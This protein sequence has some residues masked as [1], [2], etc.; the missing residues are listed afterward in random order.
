MLCWMQHSDPQDLLGSLSAVLGPSTA[1]PP[2]CACGRLRRWQH[3]KR[4]S[5]RP[6]LPELPSTSAP[7]Q[8]A[9][10]RTFSSISFI[11]LP[12]PT[13]S[14]VLSEPG[15]GSMAPAVPRGPGIHTSGRALPQ[16]SRELRSS[17]ANAPV[18][19]QEQILVCLGHS[20]GLGTSFSRNAALT[21]HN[22]CC[23]AA[24]LPGMGFL[25]H[26]LESHGALLLLPSLAAP[27]C[28]LQLHFPSPK[29]IK[30]LNFPLTLPNPA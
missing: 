7:C 3:W 9:A 11:K 16:R 27:L 26:T 13:M 8:A 17:R 15:R 20:G 1:A 21:G 5:C 28:A 18:S 24:S 14:Q 23:C 25:G 19:H 4:H 29:C 6:L 30:K 2:A 10:P 12:S 22:S